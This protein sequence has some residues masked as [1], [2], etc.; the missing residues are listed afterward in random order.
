[1]P[2]GVKNAA[3][4]IAYFCHDPTCAEIILSAF[5]WRMSGKTPNKLLAEVTPIVELGGDFC[6]S[7]GLFIP[8]Q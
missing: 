3:G 8:L 7:S 5:A 4:L 2:R 1:M 6:F